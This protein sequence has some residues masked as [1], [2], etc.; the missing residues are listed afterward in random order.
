[1]NTLLLSNVLVFLYPRWMD[2]DDRTFVQLD[3]SSQL[4][5]RF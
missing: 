2:D 3:F 5:F 4:S 1:V